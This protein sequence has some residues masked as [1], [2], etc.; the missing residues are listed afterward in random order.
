[1]GV[2]A[3]TKDNIGR[4]ERLQQR[5][6]EFKYLRVKIYKKDRQKNNIKNRINKGRAVTA[7]LN[8]VLWNTQIT[9]KKQI[10]NI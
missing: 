5:I 1:M 4:S 10:T 8:S 9:R 6:E 7:M 2:G 3:E